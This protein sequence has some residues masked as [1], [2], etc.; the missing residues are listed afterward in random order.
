MPDELNGAPDGHW[1][2]RVCSALVTR[3]YAGDTLVFESSDPVLWAAVADVIRRGAGVKNACEELAEATKQLSYAMEV[4]ARKL[5]A[6]IAASTEN[7][8]STDGDDA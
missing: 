3:L 1:Q 4:E 7:G 6:R 5:Q 2:H 8:T